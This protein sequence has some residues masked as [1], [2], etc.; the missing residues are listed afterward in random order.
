[1]LLVKDKRKIVREALKEARLR[2]GLR[3]QDVAQ[4]LGR[5]QSFVAKVESGERKADFVETL[6]LCAAVGLDPKTLLKK[7]S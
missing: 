3:Q 4:A 1:M 2:H 5:P 7:L 6:D